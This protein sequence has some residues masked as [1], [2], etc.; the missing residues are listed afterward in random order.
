MSRWRGLLV[1]QA[2]EISQYDTV[3]KMVNQFNKRVVDTAVQYKRLMH[4]QLSTMVDRVE[5]QN[6]R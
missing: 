4:L 3:V 1:D 5:M 6:N 2:Y